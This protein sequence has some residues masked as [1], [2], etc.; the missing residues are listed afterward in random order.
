MISKRKTLKSTCQKLLAQ[1]E[2]EFSSNV[3][4]IVDLYFLYLYRKTKKKCFQKLLVRFEDNLAQ[5]FLLPMLLSFS[6]PSKIM[7]AMGG[8]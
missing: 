6:D 7:S 1:F 2:K 5:L 8:N 4:I 3:L